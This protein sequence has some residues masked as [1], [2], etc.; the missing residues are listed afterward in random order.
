MDEDDFLG[1]QISLVNYWIKKC[2]LELISPLE[3]LNCCAG[4]L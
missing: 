2:T 4:S 1:A 3:N